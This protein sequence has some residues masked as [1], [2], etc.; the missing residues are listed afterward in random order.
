M[1]NTLT[2]TK[3]FDASHEDVGCSPYVHGHTFVV[4]ATGTKDLEEALESIIQEVHLRE[5]GR[6]LN[7]GAQ[8]PGALAAWFLERL[9]VTNPEVDSVTVS[10]M[11][12]AATAER[13]RR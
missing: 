3:R 5:L 7:G 4:S 1:K 9:M 13:E 12:R 8:Y 2:I 6:M 11:D 10:F